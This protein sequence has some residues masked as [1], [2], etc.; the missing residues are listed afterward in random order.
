ML[1]VERH[2]TARLALQRHRQPSPQLDHLLGQIKTTLIT[3]RIQ[4]TQTKNGTFGFG[5]GKDPG[6]AMQMGQ[7][8]VF[9]ALCR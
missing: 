7:T 8:A 1:A 5:T 3:G 2:S 9:G 6:S 4:H